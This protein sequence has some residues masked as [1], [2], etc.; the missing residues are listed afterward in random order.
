MR[1]WQAPVRTRRFS[2]FVGGDVA[3]SAAVVEG[4]GGFEVHHGWIARE[5]RVERLRSVRAATDTSP[6]GLLPRS[7]RLELEDENGGF[8]VATGEVAGCAPMR[9]ARNRRETLVC[10]SLVR[11]EMDGRHGHGT[12]EHLVQLDAKGAPVVP[13]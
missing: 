10:E 11:F 1:D 9:S 6:D 5:G 7:I 3:V 4:E 12:A 13:L 2:F 8:H